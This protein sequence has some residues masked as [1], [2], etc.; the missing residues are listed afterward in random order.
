MADRTTAPMMIIPTDDQL[1][2]CITSPRAAPA[3]GGCSVS[4][5]TISTMLSPSVRAA[6]A[7]RMDGEDSTI[8]EISGIQYCDDYGPRH[9]P[10]H[11]T[12]HDLAGSGCDAV[13]H[14]EDGEDC[15]SHRDYYCDVQDHILD[16]HD[17]QEG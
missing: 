13:G 11:V 12:A 6:T 7:L 3:A 1:H 14:D 8:A 4:V 15:G 17:G 5:T 2:P 9:D 16:D 10:C